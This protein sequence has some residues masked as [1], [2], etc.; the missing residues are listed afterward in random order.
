VS[1]SF[2][3]NTSHW[4]SDSS[5]VRVNVKHV[6]AIAPSDRNPESTGL[7]HY[8]TS[9]KRIALGGRVRPAHAGGTVR[10]RLLRRAV[11]GSYVEV[12]EKW[13][14]LDGSG[15]FVQRFSLPNRKSGTR[16]RVAAKMPEDGA[17]E[18]GYSGPTYLVVD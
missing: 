10:V 8:R 4:G 7:Y 14:E 18:N 16:Y 13:P 15:R 12:A 9:E 5:V 17:H 11:K 2:S 6:V 1:A 3:T